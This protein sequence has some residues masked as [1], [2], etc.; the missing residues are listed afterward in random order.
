MKTDFCFQI[1]KSIKRTIIKTITKTCICK[2]YDIQPQ[3]TDL[4][5][6]QVLAE[7]TDFFQS[8]IR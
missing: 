7:K 1:D 8:L 2:T 6:A 5:L 4:Y 3:K